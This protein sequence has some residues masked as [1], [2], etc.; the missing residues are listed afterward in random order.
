MTAKSK[1]T[2]KLD[3]EKAM[4]KLE[5]IVDK[6]ESGEL[7]LENSITAFE[8]GIELSKYCRKKLEAAESRVKKLI[9]NS[10]GEFDLE[11]FDDEGSSD[12]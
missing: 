5:A 11:L 4:E 8:E 1:K 7:T 12:E 6:L 10:D 3:F 2:E 9:E